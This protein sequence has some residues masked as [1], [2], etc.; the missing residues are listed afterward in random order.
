M[1]VEKENLEIIQHLVSNPNIDV[2]IK[3]IL[4]NFIFINYIEILKF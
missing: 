3:S 2:N 1:A 4:N